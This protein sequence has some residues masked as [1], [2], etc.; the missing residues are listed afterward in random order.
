MRTGKLML[1]LEKIAQL[2][3]SVEHDET[4]PGS[5]AEI[6]HLGF[7]RGLSQAAKIARRSLTFDREVL[8]RTPD[9]SLPYSSF[10][11][12]EKAHLHNLRS[13]ISEIER[14]YHSITVELSNLLTKRKHAPDDRLDDFEIELVV[15]L[16][17]PGDT[18]IQG[19]ADDRIGMV[20]EHLT[21]VDETPDFGFGA[22]DTNH[23]EPGKIQEEPQCWTYHQLRDHEVLKLQDLLRTFPAISESVGSNLRLA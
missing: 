10:S 13:V 12:G 11:D 8:G 1:A 14:H 7:R 2:E 23:A 6:D 18:D 20:T 5:L 4:E 15:E 22:V 21:Y 16:Y 17:P 3:N 19:Y 9:G